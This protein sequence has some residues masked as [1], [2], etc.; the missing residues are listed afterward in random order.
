MQTTQGLLGLGVFLLIG[1]VFSHNKKGI[2]WRLIISGLLLQLVLSVMLLKTPLLVDV[3][4]FISKCFVKVMDFSL[5]GA[6]F[7]FGDLAKN[8]LAVSNAKHNLGFIFAFQVLP[9]IVFFSMLTSGLYYAGILQKVVWALAWVMS[10][11]MRISGAESLSAAG[12]IFLGQTEAP[13]LIKPF[14]PQMTKSEIMCVMTG[15]MA[16]IAGGVM[17]AYIQFMGGTEM[18]SKIQFASYFITAS[19][20]NA[21][22]GIAFAKLI[23]PQ[24]EVIDAQLNIN[25]EKFGANLMEALTIGVTEGVKLAANVGA[26]LLAFI[27]LIALLNYILEFAGGVIGV[28]PYINNIT[29]GIFSRFNM[30][31]ILGELYRIFAFLMGVPWGETLQVGSLL[32]QKTVLNEFLSYIDLAQMK[33]DGSISRQ[34]VIISTFALCGFSNFSSIAIQVGAMSVM[35]PQ[36][37]AVF[38]EMGFRALLAASLACFTSGIWAGLLL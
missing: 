34:S 20:M 19:I 8:S 7:V 31:F 37:R 23:Y 17:A 30:Q 26:M 36:K 10:K 18:E 35:A 13:L 22:A 24:T 28:N 4:H 21:P 27:A 3:F 25:K 16:T 5:I 2:D 9:T 11:T 38:A 6:Q 12:N 29:N 15:G 14:I 32:G 33:E 1:Y